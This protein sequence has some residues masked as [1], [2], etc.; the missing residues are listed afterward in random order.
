MELAK[1]ALTDMISPGTRREITVE[2]IAETV[3]DHF[4]ITVKDLLSSKRHSNIVFPRHIC[5]Y[6]CRDL[7]SNSLADIGSRLGNRHHSTILHSIE[8]IEKKLK[9]GQE[10]KELKKTLDVLNK[11]INPQ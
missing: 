11:K 6:L 5:M 3:A 2:Y 7:T 10:N 8:L 4:G 1:E 9:N